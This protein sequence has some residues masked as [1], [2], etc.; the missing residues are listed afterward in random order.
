MLACRT[1]TFSAGSVW[2]SRTRPPRAYLTA[3]EKLEENP[4]APP[5]FSLLNPEDFCSALGHRDF[6]TLVAQAS[7]SCISRPYLMRF[8]GSTGHTWNHLIN[9][10]SWFA[11]CLSSPQTS[12]LQKAAR[13]HLC[14]P[15]SGRNP[16]NTCWRTDKLRQLSF[17]HP[18]CFKWASQVAQW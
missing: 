18:L 8:S 12:Q 14:V 9:Y 2:T 4:S 1:G 15:G 17:G 11:Y 16:L 10:V 6:P 13:L 3:A 5:V 7:S